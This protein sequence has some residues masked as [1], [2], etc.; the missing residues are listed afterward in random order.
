MRRPRPVSSWRWG[1]AAFKTNP[2]LQWMRRGVVLNLAA[3]G[4]LVQILKQARIL[5]YDDGDDDHDVNS[6]DGGSEPVGL[7]RNRNNNGL[8]TSVFTGYNQMCSK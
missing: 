6:D 8:Y 7:S 1:Q 5:C 4:A 3:R 2:P